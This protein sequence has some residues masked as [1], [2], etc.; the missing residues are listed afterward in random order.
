MPAGTQQTVVIIP[1]RLGST[2]LPGKVLLDRTGRPLI[3]HVWEAARRSTTAGRV[4]IATDDRRV[5]EVAL[6][7]GAE[8]VM[9]RA[10]HPNGTTRLAEAAALL[11][12]AADDLV[13]NVQGDEPELEPEAIDAAVGALRASEAEG[14][15]GETE[16]ASIGTIGVP[17][18]EG[19][20]PRDPNCVKVVRDARGRALYF[21]RSLIPFDRDARREPAARPLRHVGL[22]AYRRAFLE[23][24]AALPPTPLERAEQLEQLRALE[25]GHSIAV[26]ERPSAQV[27]IDTPEQYEA[28]VR[29]WGARV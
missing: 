1:A 16:G 2:R 22:Y 27:G 24:Y 12:L 6:G 8:T 26:A 28:F 21:S 17:F 11:G 25:H 13:V 10:D 5:H 9:T 18:A 14:R 29:R 23:V 4:V 7:F 3:R 19:E 20:D 15:G